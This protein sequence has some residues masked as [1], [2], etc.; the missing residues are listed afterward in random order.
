MALT[1]DVVKA[2]GGGGDAGMDVDV[3]GAGGEA[4]RRLLGDYATPARWLFLLSAPL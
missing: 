2:Q 3:D 1:D 4:P